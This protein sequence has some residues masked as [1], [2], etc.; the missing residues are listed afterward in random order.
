M[1]RQR[2]SRET[3]ERVLDAAEALLAEDGPAAITTTRIAARA[4]V[5][6]GSVYA[7]FADKNAVAEAIALR[8]W[9]RFADLAAA[10]ADAEEQDAAGRPLASVVDALAAGFRGQPAFL[11]LWY[12]DL[13]TES[14]RAATRPIRDRVAG[15]VQRALRVHWSGADAARLEVVARTLVIAGDG[16]LREAFR[17]DPQGDPVLLDETRTMLEAYA[18]AALG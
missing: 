15:S 4:G 14:M 5:A 1:P 9:Q 12:G 6:V 7:Y 3:A 16:L 13:R 8:H 10:A 18:A 17:A 2:R 11:A